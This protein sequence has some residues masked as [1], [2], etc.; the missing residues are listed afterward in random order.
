[1]V[2]WRLV[3]LNLGEFLHSL[4]RRLSPFDLVE[5]FV[6]ACNG[7]ITKAHVDLL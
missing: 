2:C 3:K 6:L 5:L 1:M 7:L 4:D